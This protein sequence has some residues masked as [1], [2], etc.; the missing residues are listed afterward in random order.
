MFGDDDADELNEMAVSL[1]RQGRSRESLEAFQRAASLYRLMADDQGE[2]R[3]LNGVGALYKDMGQTQKAAEAL[4]QA[5]VLRRKCRD[6]LG[7]AIT[8]TTIGPIYQRLGRADAARD[9][10]AQALELTRL[11][12]HRPREGQA[13]YNLAVVESD[14]GHPGAAYP[15][16]QKALAI[17]REIGDP[18]EGLKCLSALGAVCD[19]L[20]NKKEAMTYCKEA[21]GLS[22][23]FDHAPG[24]STALHNMGIIVQGTLSAPQ[25]LQFFEQ[26]LEIDLKSGAVGEAAKTMTKLVALYLNAGDVNRA[27]E[28]AK[29][30]L[31]IANQIG[32]DVLKVEAI[33]CHGKIQQAHNDF[34]AAL[35]TFEEAL[36]LAQKLGDRQLEAIVLFATAWALDLSGD[37]I[38]AFTQFER[39]ILIYD[40]EYKEL[41]REDFRISFFNSFSVQNEYLIYVSRLI[42]YSHKTGDPAYAIR[43][44]QVN[45]RRHARGLREFLQS[46]EAKDRHALGTHSTQGQNQHLQAGQQEVHAPT[47]EQV[48]KSLLNENTALLVYSLHDKVSYCWV[49]TKAN[50]EV[51][52]LPLGGSELRELV[53]QFRQ[54]L[55]GGSDSYRMLGHDLYE[56]LLQPVA[57]WIKGIKNLLIVPDL[58]LHLLPFQILLTEPHTVTGNRLPDREL[59][60]LL[61]KHAITYGPSAAVL[62]DFCQSS[63]S[64][65][66]QKLDLIAYAPVHFAAKGISDN[67]ESLPGTVEEV[68]RIASM[69]HADRV[70]VKTVHAASKSALLSEQLNDCRFLHFATH[71]Y[72]NDA[73]PEGVV[74]VLHGSDQADGVLR[75]TEIAHL[76]L[77]TEMVVLSACETAIGDVKAGEGVLGLVRG[78]FCAGSRSVCASMWKVNDQATSLL[79]G[80]FYE[81][82]AAKGLSKAESLRLSQLDFVRSDQWAH[83]RHWGAFVLAGDGC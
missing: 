2:A 39:A 7:E 34:I 13:L 58:A 78:F 51:V 28:L 3:C 4:E 19:R 61:R 41:D 80:K 42:K 33:V 6:R 48:Q 23:R 47:I 70:V 36:Q 9:S 20:G 46:K 45:E 21:L 69:F 67:L 59:P 74:I 8:L 65:V 27:N 11:L 17:A 63:G 83:P 12:Q 26:S 77:N 64:S 66:N 56:I 35:Q 16:F 79:M 82:R 37:S 43:A 25:G 14:A 40:H 57:N 62:T 72:L 68:T 75:S 22:K 71:S 55:I 1:Q 29:Q 60:Y 10:L 50:H 76:A 24:M 54:S 15:L 5:L 30:A 81:N 52:S 53:E 38:A 31:D 44:F 32:D 73:G 49:V 18:T